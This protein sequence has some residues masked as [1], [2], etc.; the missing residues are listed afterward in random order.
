M[1]NYI[2]LL[3][4]HPYNYSCRKGNNSTIFSDIIHSN[5]YLFSIARLVLFVSKPLP[6]IFKVTSKLMTTSKAYDKLII[7]SKVKN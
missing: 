5:L 6:N 7:N 4:M 3:S 1:K 2:L